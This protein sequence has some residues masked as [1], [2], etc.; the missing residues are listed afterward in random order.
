MPVDY[1]TGKTKAYPGFKKARAQGVQVQGA[2]TTSMDQ[3]VKKP[4]NGNPKKMKP[5]T[6]Y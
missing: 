3:S 2:D 5:R 4:K 6:S 1:K